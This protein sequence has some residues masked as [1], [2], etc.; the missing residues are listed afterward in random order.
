MDLLASQVN[1][2]DFDWPITVWRYP[3]VLRTT[4]EVGKGPMGKVKST[5][6]LMRRSNNN[7]RALQPE[8]AQPEQSM[9]QNGQHS[10]HWSYLSRDP[11]KG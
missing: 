2:T 4:R 3:L 5:G 9:E 6:L 1:H 11:S 8:A 7:D 10:F